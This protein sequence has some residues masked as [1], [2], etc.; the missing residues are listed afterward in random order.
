MLSCNDEPSSY[1]DYQD[2]N[3]NAVNTNAHNHN[4]SDQAGT[5]LGRTPSPT[6]IEEGH[7]QMSEGD[8][9]MDMEVCPEEE[10]DDNQGT[11]HGFAASPDPYESRQLQT[12]RT[13][14]S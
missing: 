10:S 13:S 4:H 9:T 3:I 1:N 2:I 12:G 14:F 6:T 11:D 5:L 8:I 7:I